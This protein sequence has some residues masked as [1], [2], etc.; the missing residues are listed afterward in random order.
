[1]ESPLEGITIIEVD[2][3]VA[4]PSA[5]AILADLGARV[6]K[7]EPLTGDPW[8]GLSRPTKNDGL[9]EAIQKMDLQFDV[10]NRGKE[11]IAVALDQP[12]GAELVRKLIAKADIFMCNLLIHRQEKFGLDPETLL[13]LRPNL[14]HATLTGYGTSGP[15]ALR[16]GYDV[17]AF[18][19][20]SGLYDALREGEDGMVPMARP[21]QGDHTTGLAFV[22]AILAALRLAEKTGE[23][24]VVE[25]SLYETAVWT[26]AS[27]YAVTAVDHAPVRRR[28]RKELFAITGNRFPCGDGKWVVFNMMPDTA[29]WA[30]MCRAIGIEE[31]IDDERF[32]D[33]RARY[34][35]MAELIDLLDTAL[36]KKSRDDWGSI[37]DKAGLIWG[38]VLGLH[39][40]AQDPHAIELGMF[41]EMEHREAGVYRTVN[42]PMRFARTQVKPRSPAPDIGEHTSSVLAELG[43][44]EEEIDAMSKAKTIGRGKR[45]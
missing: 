8:R 21:A 13:E 22:G 12:E 43:F 41:P 7:I 27:D 44:S 9:S 28:T 33:S 36:A 1:M 2:N 5:A 10:D 26:Q 15:D 40:V 17:T 32:I 20:R 6:I 39:E 37:F 11:S 34:R 3:F 14:V 38:P 25:T 24:Q 45:A 29:Y 35:N 30:P 19:G 23:G 4:A 18:F 42:I 16:P 31:L